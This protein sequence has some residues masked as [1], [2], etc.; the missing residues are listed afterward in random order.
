MSLATKRALS[1]ARKIKK[2]TR[3]QLESLAFR[4]GLHLST[5]Y[6]ALKNSP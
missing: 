6:R 3:Q 2:P 4:Y 1:H 5:L